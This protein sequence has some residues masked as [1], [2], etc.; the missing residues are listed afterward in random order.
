MLNDARHGDAGDHRRMEDGTPG[1][2]R[3]AARAT[4]RN[5]NPARGEIGHAV[6]GMTP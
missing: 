3:C 1:G 5:G 6:I 2:A 4:W